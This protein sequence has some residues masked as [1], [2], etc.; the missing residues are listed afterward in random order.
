M[1]NT[2]DIIR[3]LGRVEGKVDGINKRLDTMNG[4]ISNHDTRI[5][6]NETHI[7]KMTGKATVI[8]GVMGFIGAAVIAFFSLF[9]K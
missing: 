4:S 9:S 7:D 8:G 2:K 1:E 6:A 5:N 3:G